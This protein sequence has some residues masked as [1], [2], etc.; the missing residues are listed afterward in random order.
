M[1]CILKV[2][3]VDLAGQNAPIRGELLSAVERV[4]Q[5]GQ[6]ILGEEVSTFEQ[7]FAQLCGT[8]YAVGVHS[9]TDALILA[10]RALRIGPGDEVITVPNAYIS[11]ASCVVCV[12]ARPVFVD[13]RD[14]Y[15]LDPSLLERAITRRTKAI[16]PVHL[17]GRAADMVSIVA[18]AKKHRLAVVEDCAQAVSAEINGRKVGSFGNIGCFSLHPLKTLNA[19]GDGGV[20]VTDDPQIYENV[21]ILRNNGFRSQY[22]CVVFSSNSRL[23][24]VQ[25]AMLNAKMRYLEEWTEGRRANARVY[26]K[27]L[28]GLSRI[29]LPVDKPGERAVY[30][31]F[32]IQADRRDELREFLSERGIGTK[33]HYPIPVHLQVAAKGLGYKK[34]D[35]PITERQAE[36]ILSLPVYSGLEPDQ[37][38]HVG[39]CIREFFKEQK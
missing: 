4:L 26:Q 33:I 20:L 30:H 9:G 36:R 25:A 7:R 34:G 14:D 18:V 16:L 1:Q 2:P 17:T 10:L 13:V 6:F 27:E 39:E 12:G 31:T 38:A 3:Y 24:S 11:A 28:S 15:N 8:K 21:M 5:S 19:C 23:D 37:L 22:E 29:Q 35:F 32:V